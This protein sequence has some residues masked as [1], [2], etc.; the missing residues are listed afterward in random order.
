MFSIAIF[1]FQITPSSSP[2]FEPSVAVNL[3]SPDIMIATSVTFVGNV[4]MTGVYQSLD[5][6][7]TWV[8]TILP[9]PAGYAGAEAPYVAYGFPTNFFIAV[10]AFTADGLNGS[11]FVYRSFDNGFNF[12]TPIL[13]APGYGVYINNDEPIIEI[14]VSQCSPYLANTYVGYNHQFNIT[15]NPRT[16]FMFQRSLDNGATW[17]QPTLMSSPQDIVE[18]PDIATSLTGIVYG[19]WINTNPPNTAFQVRVSADGGAT[20]S[21]TIVIS[22]VVLV[23]TVLPVPGYAF[24]V[25]T[26]PNLGVDRTTLSTSGRVYAVWQDNRL[27]YSDIFMSI[28]NN[29]GATWSTPV[30]I[31][32][33]PAGSQNFFPAIDIDP[34][35]GVVNVIYYTNRVNGFL[36]DV[37]TAR[38]IN[39]GQSFTNQRITSQSFDPNLGGPTPV[40]V[41]GDYIDIK[42]VTPSG[43]IGVWTDTRTGALAIFSGFNTDPVS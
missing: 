17:M 21:N 1:N 7:A 35:A 26:F 11:T 43:Y 19:G 16:A 13:V 41:I 4:P 15:S 32:G 27:G 38:S 39:G 33:A 20:F 40:T 12:Q 42:T 14:D 28:S 34:L 30:S 31:T 18:R 3:L 23:P 10:H 9:L 2:S 37:F 6:G 22:N 36:L 5:G 25:L 24:R 8:N 29:Q